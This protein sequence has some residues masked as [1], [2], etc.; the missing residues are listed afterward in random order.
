MSRTVMAVLGVILALYVVFGL[1][2][3][4][5]FGLLKF[6]VVLALVAFVVVAVVTVAGKFAK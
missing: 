2:L 3:P 5:L 1:V 4:A 6:L